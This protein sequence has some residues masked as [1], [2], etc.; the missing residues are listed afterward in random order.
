MLKHFFNF[1]FFY[2]GSDLHLSHKNLIIPLQVKTDMDFEIVK[3]ED[4][5]VVGDREEMFSKLEKDLIE[6]VCS[7]MHF[8]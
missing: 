1:H 8:V 7:N 6:Q 2:V 4:C 5:A 3:R